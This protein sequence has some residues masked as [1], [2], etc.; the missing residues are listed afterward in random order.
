MTTAEKGLVVAVAI[1]T[2]ALITVV[3][4]AGVLPLGDSPLQHLLRKGTR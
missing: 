1:A 4:L 2:S 3:W